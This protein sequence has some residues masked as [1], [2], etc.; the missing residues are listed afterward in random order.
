MDTLPSGRYIKHSALV[1]ALGFLPG[2]SESSTTK[3]FSSAFEAGAAPGG[4]AAASHWHFD[5]LFYT[6]GRRPRA[7]RAAKFS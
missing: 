1:L 5:P 4:A 2:G 6:A 7:R 3:D